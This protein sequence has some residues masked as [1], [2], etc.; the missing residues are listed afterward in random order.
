MGGAGLLPGG[1]SQEELRQFEIAWLRDLHITE[2]AGHH[3]NLKA[4]TFDHARFIGATEA[5]GFGFSKGPLQ[6]RYAKS[7]RRLC[8]HNALAGDGGGDTGAGGGAL[9]LLDGV[10][11]GQAHNGCSMH[12]HRLYGTGDQPGGNQ[13]ADCVMHQDDVV[14]V[15]RPGLRCRR[16]QC[17]EGTGDAVL[18]GIASLDNAHV[19]GEAVLVNE[20]CQ[21]LALIAADGHV[22]RRYIRNR[23]KGAQGVDQNG[24]A[25]EFKELLGLS[26]DLRLGAAD[27]RHARAKPRCGKYHKDSHRRSSIQPDCT[28]WHCAGARC[29]LSRPRSVRRKAVHCGPNPTSVRSLESYMNPAARSARSS[30]L[31]PPAARLLAAVLVCV[32]M[33][34]A[35]PAQARKQPPAA[36]TVAASPALGWNSWDSYG[37]TVTADEFKRN[38]DWF[39]QHLKPSGWQYVVVDEGWYLAHPEVAGT[40]GA[41]QGFTFDANGRYTPAQSRFPGGLKALADYAHQRGLKFGIHIIKGIPRTAVEKD[42]SILGSNAHAAEA[43]DTADT[44][45]WN[46]D[47]YGVKDNAAG[48]AYYDSVLALYAEW[49]VDFL[50]VDCISKPYNA[51]EIHMISAA[52][53]KTGR[54]I[55]LSLSPGPTPLD[56]ASDVIQYAQQ[57][58]ISEDFWDVWGNPAVAQGAF[59]Q[60]VINQFANLAAWAPYAGP[61]HWPDADMLPIGYLGPR[62]GYGPPRLS[63]LNY[64]ET[65]TLLTLWSMA[66]SPL[67]LGANLT[68]LDAFDETMLTNAEV[69][70]VDQHSIGG[71]PLPALA[72][73]GK[74]AVWRAEEPKGGK[75]SFIAVFNLGD[76]STDLS[77]SWKDLGFKGSEHRV[78]DLWQAQEL[79]KQPVLKTTLPAHGTALFRVD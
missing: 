16:Y 41:D 50:K 20:S 10:D 53:K 37:L 26:R 68:Q 69:L 3:C 71:H 67:I 9:Y 34:G 12:A 77:Y 59:P 29:Q 43:A 74:S 79:G 56:Q 52:I 19:G 2:R 24:H 44:C 5:V 40:K 65:R 31:L 28:D 22:D 48:Q 49:G 14:I 4:C 55:L 57:W 36:P 54:P 61:G 6:Q 58:R 76:A 60:S 73:P 47:N 75:R 72:Q 51:H 38:V 11:G 66:R 32:G 42:L 21:A 63:H 23:G 64:D 8:L 46:S 70:F 7:L 15:Q 33:L 62:P 1:A 78:R 25:G 39:V 17:M 13:R 27:R 35:V 30:C 45:R 18:P